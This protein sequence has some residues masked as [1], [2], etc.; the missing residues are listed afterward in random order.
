MELGEF[1]RHMAT[2]LMRDKDDETVKETKKSLTVS[3]LQSVLWRSES[4]VMLL[5]FLLVLAQTSRY[6]PAFYRHTRWKTLK[7]LPRT[8]DRYAYTLVVEALL[9]KYYLGLMSD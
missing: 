6:P 9:I 2:R 3:L 8:A 4:F 1:Y 5:Q 7:V